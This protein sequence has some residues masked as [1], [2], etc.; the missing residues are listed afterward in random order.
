MSNK[1]HLAAPR[2]VISEQSTAW[3][4][5]LEMMPYGKHLTAASEAPYRSIYGDHLHAIIPN[6]LALKKIVKHP[7]HKNPKKKEP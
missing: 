5:T 7:P 6:W 4:L 2:Y 3:H 1:P